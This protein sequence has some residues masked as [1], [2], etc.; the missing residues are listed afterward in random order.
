MCTKQCCERQFC[1]LTVAYART[2]H[3]FQGLTVGPV[4]EGKPKN[5]YDVVICDVDEKQQEGV[6]LG[7]LYTAVSRGTTLGNDDGSDS[8]VYF[9]GTTFKPERIRNLTCKTGTNEEFKKAQQRRYWVNHIEKRTRESIP[10]V[11]AIINDQQAILHWTN[12]T[13]FSLDHLYQ[14][15]DIYTR[16]SHI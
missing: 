12:N 2:I 6:A 15:I 13:T 9:Q 16:R 3:K 5:I 11:K 10:R 1:P 7:L 8:A 4:P 14:R